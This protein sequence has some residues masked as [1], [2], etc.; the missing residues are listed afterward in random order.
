M[1]RIKQKHRKFENELY[2]LEKMVS[3][4]WLQ[5][6]MKYPAKEL[7]TLPAIF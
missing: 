4:A 5:G 1:V 6:L 3:A 2:M 7:E